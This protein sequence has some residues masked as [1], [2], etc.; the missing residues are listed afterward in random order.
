MRQPQ[1]FLIVVISAFAL[2]GCRA[3]GSDNVT[4][5]PAQNYQQIQQQRYLYKPQQTDQQSYQ[6]W[7]QRLGSAYPGDFWR[8][9]G[10][11][12][13][14]FAPILWDDT[15][16]IVR[17][18]GSLIMLGMA[19][20][21]GIALQGPNA[22][23]K[24]Q[25]HYEQHGSGLNTFWDTVGDAGGNPG[26][27]FALAGALYFSSL[28]REDVQTYE[29]SKTLLSGLA[30]N[31][32]ANI[33][34][35][36]AARTEAPNGNENVW[37]SG[38][39]SST[40]TLA[41]IM[42]HEYGPGVGLPLMAFASYVGYER[43]DARN[44]HFSDVISGALIGVAIGHAVSQNHQLRIGQFEVIPTLGLDSQSVGLALAKRW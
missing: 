29:T 42:W 6:P 41:T 36:A 25:R 38:H 19:G 20:A 22:D 8:S 37:P 9:F 2:V 16:S 40:F 32:L 7:S 28:A 10:R 3:G 39:T 26:V 35:K 33:A 30:L 44:H 14:E 1:F 4:A 43:I 17:E 27:H 31:G 34:L 13:K 21:A 15:T 18:P 23:D 12:A 24:I 5:L 11:D